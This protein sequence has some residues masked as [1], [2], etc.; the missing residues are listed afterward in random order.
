MSGLYGGC[1]KTSQPSSR[2]F[3]RVIKDVCGRVVV[4][5]DTSPID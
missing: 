5:D 3:C 2:N 4:E 1:I